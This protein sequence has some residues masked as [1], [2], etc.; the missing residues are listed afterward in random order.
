MPQL[1]DCTVE[2]RERLVVGA[3]HVLSLN[4]EPSKI[5]H[6]DGSFEHSRGPRSAWSGPDRWIPT[7]V[8]DQR[9]MTP[10]SGLLAVAY[11]LRGILPAR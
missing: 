8:R 3:V 4:L 10:S 11:I 7:Q 5:I 6:R 2:C 1:L 9:P